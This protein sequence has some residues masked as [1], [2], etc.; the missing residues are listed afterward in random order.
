MK[1]LITYFSMTGNTE[2]IAKG[3]FDELSDSIDEVKL[4]QITKIDSKSIKDYD[5]VFIGSACHDAD[6]AKPVKDFLKKIPSSS[7]LKLAGF[8]THSTYLNDGSK[9]RNELF[10]KWAGKCEGSFIK[11]CK[12]KGIEYLGYFHCQGKP[13]PEIA[14]FIHRV[15]VTEEEEWQEYIK[16]VNRHPDEEDI[17]NAKAFVQD[18][19][20]ML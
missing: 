18:I 12:K 13:S 19:L 20:A 8:V 4:E 3:M 16:E 1:G 7:D 14:D 9:R 6:L 17:L 5:L 2:L 11:V 15:I 10:E